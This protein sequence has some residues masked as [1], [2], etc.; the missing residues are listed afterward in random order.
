MVKDR[1]HCMSNMKVGRRPIL[2]KYDAALQRQ[3][4][5]AA[6]RKSQI[7]ESQNEKS[8]TTKSP[9][10]KYPSLLKVRMDKKP[11]FK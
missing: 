7:E 6:P 5:K 10:A 3:V 2:G 4:V 9:T 11:E 8:Q 1:S